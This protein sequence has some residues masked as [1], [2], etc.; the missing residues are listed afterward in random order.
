MEDSD[1][2]SFLDGCS[3]ASE[4]GLSGSEDEDEGAVVVGLPVSVGPPLLLCVPI[5]RFPVTLG[6]AGVGPPVTR[7]DT[8]H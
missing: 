8:K 5:Q 7:Q 1:G 3:S 6:C 4:R 2:F